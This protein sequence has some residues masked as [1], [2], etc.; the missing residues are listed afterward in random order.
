MLLSQLNHTMRLYSVI[1]D[2]R[3]IIIRT[4]SSE[5]R[6][7]FCFHVF[8]LVLLLFSVQCAITCRSCWLFVSKLNIFYRI[9]YRSRHSFIL[10]AATPFCDECRSSADLLTVLAGKV[11]QSVGCVCL[12]VCLPVCLF[13][14]YIANRLTLKFELSFCTSICGLR[15]QLARMERLRPCSQIR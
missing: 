14:L 5:L 6:P 1:T 7:L 2:P 15:P 10:C 3:I 13:P 9:V 8:L 11:K 12:S 4:V